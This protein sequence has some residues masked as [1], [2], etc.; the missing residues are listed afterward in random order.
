[1]D[2]KSGGIRPIEVG[3]VRRRLAAG[4]AIFQAID[5]LAD[6]F[7]PFQLGVEVLGGCQGT[8]H[9]TRRFLYNVSDD[10]IIAKLDFTNTFNCLHRDAVGTRK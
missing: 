8:V 5:T 9:A 1:M 6:Y 3:Y 10:Y 2:K 7:T 4:C